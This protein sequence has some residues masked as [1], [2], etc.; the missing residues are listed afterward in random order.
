M[1]T[2][3]SVVEVDDGFMPADS[4]ATV[5]VADEEGLTAPPSDGPTQGQPTITRSPVM[6]PQAPGGVLSP[7]SAGSIV[8]RP[9]QALQPP[10]LPKAERTPVIR[11]AIGRLMRRIFRMQSPEDIQREIDRVRAEIARRAEIERLKA[12]LRALRK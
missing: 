9:G 11:P 10:P 1:S 8:P 6:S 3:L 5:G 4:T 12:E 2:P 7:A